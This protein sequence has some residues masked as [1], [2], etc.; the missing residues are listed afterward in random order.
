MIKII[1]VIVTILG[2]VILTSCNLS[3]YMVYGGLDPTDDSFRG[4]VV[5]DGT[6]PKSGY[7]LPVPEG[8]DELDLVGKWVPYISSSVNTTLILHEDGTYRQL[9]DNPITGDS[10]ESSYKHRW[11]VEKLESG[12]WRV[13]LAGMKMCDHGLYSDCERYGDEAR[14][15]MWFDPCHK[16]GVNTR[17][18][19]FLLVIGLDPEK[20]FGEAPKD[21]LLK[22]PIQ[23]PDTTTGSFQLQE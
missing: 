17:E 7:C 4:V 15:G 16:E 22:Y 1:T 13:H 9:Y 3:R 23:D 14:R 10:Y 21:I 18:N 2:A 19:F 20:I 6:E 11:W 8:L 5:K 12:I